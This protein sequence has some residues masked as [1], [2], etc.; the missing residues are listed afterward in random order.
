MLT[1]KRVNITNRKKTISQR[2]SGYNFSFIYDTIIS[3]R[4]LIT[5]RKYC[6]LSFPKQTML[7]FNSIEAAI[8]EHCIERV[9]PL[10]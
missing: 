2:V 8:G 9:H 5:L 10:F 1:S 4:S 6:Y 3:I 7:Y